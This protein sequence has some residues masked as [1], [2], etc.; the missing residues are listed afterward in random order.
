MDLSPLWDDDPRTEPQRIGSYYTGGTAHKSVLRSGHLF[1]ADGQEGLKILDVTVANNPVEIGSVVSDD[2]R[3]VALIPGYALVADERRGLILCD[4]SDP[5][6]PILIKILDSRG[7]QRIALQDHLA[8]TAGK[9]GVNLYDFSDPLRP[10]LFGSFD[11]EYVES[12]FIDGK[13]LYIA[14][15]HRGLQVVDIRSFDSP[16]QVSACTDIYAVD[17]AVYN[18]YAIVADSR[19]LNVVEV[20]VPEWLRLSASRR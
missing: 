17:V 2:A 16:V 9:T 14:E 15:G 19:Q 5:S 4:I 12:I 8:A 6:D 13:Y 1:V 3:D 7:I 18:G 11:S 20:L 10:E